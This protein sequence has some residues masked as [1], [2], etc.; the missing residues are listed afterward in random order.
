MPKRP[1]SSKAVAALPADY[2]PF[3]AEIKA[4]VQSARIKAGLA[5]NRE[6][7]ALQKLGQLKRRGRGPGTRFEMATALPPSG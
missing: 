3:L 2:G 5:A 1:S 4:R 6:S 7:L